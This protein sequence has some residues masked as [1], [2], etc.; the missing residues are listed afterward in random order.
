MA[1]ARSDTPALTDEQLRQRFAQ[2]SRAGLPYNPATEPIEIKG[3]NLARL[4]EG[5]NTH[6]W[7]DLRFVTEAQATAMG[8]TIKTRAPRVEINIRNSVT[9]RYQ[10]VALVNAQSVIGMPSELAM[11][12]SPLAQL[13]PPGEAEPSQE[14]GVPAVSTQVGL[15]ESQDDLMTIAPAGPHVDL[16]PEAEQKAPTLQ[17]GKAPNEAQGLQPGYRWLLAH[18]AD[19]YLG[20]PKNNP[21]YFVELEDSAGERTTLWGLG[22]QQSLVDAGARIGDA[23]AIEEIGRKDVTVQVLD[24]GKLVEKPGQRVEWRTS[25]QPSQPEKSRE[26]QQASPASRA[27]LA[28]ADHPQH[29]M[30]VP[31][32]ARFAIMAPYWLHGL[33][34]FSGLAI[35]DELNRTIHKLQLT[36]SQEAI[37]KLLSAHPRAR[38][39]GLR[40]VDEAMFLEDPW[41]RTNPGEPT[42]LL[43]GE[44]VRD[45]EGAYRP[46]AG[47]KAILKDSGDSLI[48]K[49]KS[50]QAY[51]GAMELAIAKG[52]KAI[53]LNGKPAMLADAWLEAK[54]L[55]LEVVNYKP[56][57]QD[58]AR[59]AQRLAAQERG[60]GS[61]DHLEVRPA[62]S[63]PGSKV[64]AAGQHIG[65]IIE[66]G[67]DHLAQKTGRYDSSIVWHEIAALQGDQPR[68]GVS[69]EITY[70]NGK[71]T[72]SNMDRRRQLEHG[73]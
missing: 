25:L 6:G 35:A 1:N 24:E 65:P 36:S 62:P 10:R 31:S 22:L 5:M 39:L 49:N 63:Q 18:G 55:G 52:W 54:L 19:N 47:G 71:G 20:D 8:W 4:K 13:E 27:S 70:V 69:A 38:E 30:T 42:H 59:Y 14:S 7:K 51:R 2:S 66:V 58:R 57:E 11:L 56:T 34:N 33:H 64:V 29:R 48:L 68:A 16:V 40:V 37:Q 32:S 53:S 67:T 73:R 3:A 12:E 44:L 41:R 21:S 61:K 26:A 50:E 28:G 15:A 17:D 60:D 43:N 9:G 45:S 46:K 23:V 72:V